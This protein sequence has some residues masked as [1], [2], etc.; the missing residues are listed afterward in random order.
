MKSFSG[1]KSPMDVV[2][3]DAGNFLVSDVGDKCVR[4]YRITDGSIAYVINTSGEGYTLQWPL[5]VHIVRRRRPPAPHPAT[6]G[7]GIVAPCTV[8]TFGGG[9]SIISDTMQRKLLAFDDRGAFVREISLLTLGSH[10]MIRPRGIW[11]CSGESFAGSEGGGGGGKAPCFD[12]DALVVID[13][14]SD[15][16]ECF[17]SGDYS[18]VQTLIDSLEGVSLKPKVLRI[19]DDGRLLIVGGATGLVR[20]LSIKRTYVASYR[21]LT[22]CRVNL[23]DCIVDKKVLNVAIARQ[24]KNF[25]AKKASYLNRTLGIA[26]GRDIDLKVE[27]LQQGGQAECREV[28]NETV[29]NNSDGVIQINNNEENGESDDD[30]CVI[31]EDEEEEEEKEDT[32]GSVK[33][34][35]EVMQVNDP[36][37]LVNVV[38]SIAINV[39]DSTVVDV[40]DLDDDSFEII[41]HVGVDDGDVESDGAV[42]DADDVEIDEGMVYHAGDI[43]SDAAVV[44]HLGDI[45]RDAPLV[46]HQGDI[47][48]DAAVVYYAGDFDSDQDVVDIDN[49]DGDCVIVL[50]SD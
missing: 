31:L 27:V 13:D 2:V 41:D 19:S 21:D 20:L 50:E 17:D 6:K 38:E 45:L 15:S 33:D 46:Y 22:T 37:K 47:V 9:Y 32:A 4:A 39:V 25:Q 35:S 1:G 5:Y 14:S 30:D 34:T 7:G 3:D 44:F 29:D 43:E 18:H 36:S 11:T 10:H 24:L 26:D 42:D 16:V 28:L 23:S 49:E 48:S 8:E 40:V 12:G